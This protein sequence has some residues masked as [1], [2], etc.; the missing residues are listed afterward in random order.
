M[1]P[2][3][4]FEARLPEFL[5]K[6]QGQPGPGPTGFR[7]PE[8]YFE[9]L[10]D[11]VFGK[12]RDAEAGFLI[13]IDAVSTGFA[14]PDDYFEELP[15]QVF[16]KIGA[17][18]TDFLT[19]I[20]AIGGGHSVPKNYFEHL[21][22]RVLEKIKVGGFAENLNQN[23]PIFDQNPLKSTQNRSFLKIIR[24]P[25][26]LAAAASVAVLVAALGI[27]FNKKTVAPAE[28]IAC[29][30]TC[31]SEK[32][33]AEDVQKY[34]EENL[35]E[36]SAEDLSTEDLVGELNTPLPKKHQEIDVNGD[37][38]EPFLREMLDDVSEEDLQKML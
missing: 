24:R 6:K 13:E 29:N 28:S 32:I 34:L 21:T 30:A 17:S 16:E 33:S 37:D 31:L 26:V 19:E 25:A 15:E 23:R 5:E 35:A 36:F 7:T 9:K 38:A 3:E 20:K 12:I 11:R 2:L 8:G 14:V 27:F 22:D 4:N 1:E 10:G 18:E